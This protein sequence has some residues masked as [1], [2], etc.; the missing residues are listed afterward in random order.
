MAVLILAAN[1]T[2]IMIS[3][4][5]FTTAEVV[6]WYYPLYLRVRLRAWLLRPSPSAEL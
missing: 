3:E 1:L 6:W 5:K 2:V 4:H